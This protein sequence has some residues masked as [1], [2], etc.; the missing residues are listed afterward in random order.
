[1]LYRYVITLIAAGVLAAAA[2][3]KARD[4]E[5]LTLPTQQPGGRSR[6]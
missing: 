4:L 2:Y 1:M 6:F 5:S 3:L